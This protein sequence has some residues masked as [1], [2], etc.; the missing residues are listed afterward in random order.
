MD[1][2]G[3]LNQLCAAAGT[4]WLVAVAIA[5]FTMICESAG[6][7]VEPGEEKPKPGPLRVASLILSLFTPILLFVHAYWAVALLEQ[8][9]PPDGPLALVLLAFRSVALAALY[10]VMLALILA[11]GAFAAL[12][13]KLSKPLARALYAAAP[14]L[15]IATFAFAVF[16]TRHNVASAIDLIVYRLSPA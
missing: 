13:R 15:T 5:F 6:P 16:A 3:A 1:G 9:G 8:A 7:V 12:A 2:P 14:V 10:I 11:P 4:T